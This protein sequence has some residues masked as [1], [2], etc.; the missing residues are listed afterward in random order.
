MVRRDARAFSAPVGFD[1]SGGGK[2]RADGALDQWRAVRRDDAQRPSRGADGAVLGGGAGYRV[3]VFARGRRQ[4]LQPLSVA[5]AERALRAI[6]WRCART[7]R[8]DT[9]SA[10]RQANRIR[11]IR[12]IQ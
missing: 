1:R 10:R 9:A 2:P 6:G 8:A 5:V 12:V 4:L 7:D 3:A 11:L